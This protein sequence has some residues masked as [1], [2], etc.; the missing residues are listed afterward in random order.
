MAKSILATNLKK[1]MSDRNITQQVLSDGTKIPITRIRTWFTDNKSRKP[2][3][4]SIEDFM[5]V[6]AFLNVR[7]EDL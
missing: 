3:T 7:A 6:A 1:V 4:P 2:S 5:A